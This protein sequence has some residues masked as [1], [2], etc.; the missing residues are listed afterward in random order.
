MAGTRREALAAGAVVVPIGVVG[1]L[2]TF[3][4]RKNGGKTLETTTALV[5]QPSHGGGGDPALAGG[6]KSHEEATRRAW[7][8]DSSDDLK[9]LNR[10]RLRAIGESHVITVAD[11]TNFSSSF[12]VVVQ[13][14]LPSTGLKLRLD[15]AVAQGK[16]VIVEVSSR[17]PNGGA[18][19]NAEVELATLFVRCSRDS[20]S[21]VDTVRVRYEN[22]ISEGTIEART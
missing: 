17:S 18:G 1:I 3:D 21:A 14:V 11:N 2:T 22:T 12:L 8:F 6:L 9:K 5:E 4:W 16:A 13:A 19:G 20:I 7:V 15:R 10:E